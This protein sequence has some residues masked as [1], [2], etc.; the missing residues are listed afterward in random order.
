MAIDI[1]NQEAIR[2]LKWEDLVQDAVERKDKTALRWLED[3]SVETKERVNKET[4]ETTT[5]NLSIVEVRAEYLKK[6]LAYVPVGKQNAEARKA[7]EK[8]KREAKRKSLFAAA[9]EAIGE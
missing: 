8:A 7:A 6:F 9:F 4:G 3:K 2:K 1:T 5:V